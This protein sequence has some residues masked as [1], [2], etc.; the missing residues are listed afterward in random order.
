MPCRCRVFEPCLTPMS[1]QL[2]LSLSVI[3]AYPWLVDWR[4]LDGS[5]LMVLVWP[6]LKQHWRLP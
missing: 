4:L 6:N 1:T 3:A 5:C 2:N